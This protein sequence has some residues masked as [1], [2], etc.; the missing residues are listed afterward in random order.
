MGTLII[1]SGIRFNGF[2]ITLNDRFKGGVWN[3]YYLMIK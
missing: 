3:M 2:G 1:A